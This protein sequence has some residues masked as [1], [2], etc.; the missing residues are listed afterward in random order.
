MANFTE[1]LIW[2]DDVRQVSNFLTTASDLAG[3]YKLV[4]TR[5]ITP[6]TK[7]VILLYT[8]QDS[9]ITVEQKSSEVFLPAFIV[10][11]VVSDSNESFKRG[12]IQMRPGEQIAHLA[13]NLKSLQSVRNLLEYISNSLKKSYKILIFS[14]SHKGMR[15]VKWVSFISSLLSALLSILVIFIA[16]IIS[17]SR[18]SAEKRWFSNSLL[19]SGNLTFV[20][21]FVGFYGVKK[22][23]IKEYLKIYSGVLFINALYKVILII[24]HAFVK[25][26]HMMQQIMIPI[27]VT[28]ILIEVFT[29]CIIFLELNVVKKV[30]SYL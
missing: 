14:L 21:S 13:I 9:F 19:T 28:S 30:N 26:D 2:G 17:I 10:N 22:S 11:L 20:M 25:W 24:A 18:E 12:S 27:V 23:G 29:A 16:G 8:N 1:I 7:A 4:L 3:Q 5:D 15:V 6:K